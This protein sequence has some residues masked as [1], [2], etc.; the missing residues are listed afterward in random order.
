MMMMIII[1][2]FR[3][4]DTHLVFFRVMTLQNGGWVGEWVGT[5]IKDEYLVF[6]YRAATFPPSS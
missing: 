5:N 2:I 3:L 6:I 1:I 4:T